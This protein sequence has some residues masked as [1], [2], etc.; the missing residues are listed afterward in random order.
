MRI[1]L[2][3]LM[4]VVA[5]FPLR[6]EESIVAGLSQNRV[7]I[8]A[9]FVGSEILIFGAVKREVAVPEGTLDVVVVVEGPGSEIT[10]RKK[11]KRAGIWVNTE[12]AQ[13][14]DVPS[15]YA[16]ATSAPFSEIVP[17]AV[18]VAEGISVKNVIALAD[19]AAQ[20]D[21]DFRDAVVR[22]RSNA[23]L[24]ALNEGAVTMREATLF[25]TRVEL[26]SNLTEGD[27]DARIYLMRGGEVVTQY[28]AQ[29]DV[30]KVGLERWLYW[31]AHQHA[32]VYAFMS[33]AIA[34]G[35][36]WGASTAFR[37][38]LRS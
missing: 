21:E 14:R 7:S 33:L 37:M 4:M 36:G 17:E 18:D 19:D 8:T 6:A 26:P 16:V 1:I 23:G 29:I 32:L 34:I 13:L 38:I 22:I 27:Y 24:Y 5:A 20:D 31:L 3:L 25:E 15:F 28:V 12:S 35:A 30:R 11:D 10:V 2:A 9:T